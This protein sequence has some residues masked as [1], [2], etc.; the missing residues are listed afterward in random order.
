M[1]EN[2]KEIF[3]TA[4]AGIQIWDLSDN[5]SLC[6]PEILSYKSGKCTVLRN[7]LNYIFPCGL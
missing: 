4:K 7:T 5:L 3:A 1:D 6:P 2:Q